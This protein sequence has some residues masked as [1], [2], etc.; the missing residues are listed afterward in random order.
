MAAAW[1]CFLTILLDG[2]DT[3]VISFAAPSLAHDWSLPAAAFTPAFVATSLGA[4]IGYVSCGHLAARFGHR[5]LVIASVSFFGLMSLATVLATDITELTVFRFVTALGLGGAIPTAIALASGHADASRREVTASI[6]TVAIVIGGTLGGLVA[7]PLLRRWGWQGPFVLGAILPFISL[8]ALIAWLPD[9]ASQGGRGSPKA[10]FAAGF[11]LPTILLWAM[12]FL[13]F[14]QSYSFTYWLPLLLTSF[15]FDRAS[16]ALG[17]T[18]IGAGGIAGV[19]LMACF[20]QRVGC[21]RYLAAA[22]TVGAGF[23]LLIAFGGLPNGTLPALLVL[24]GAGLG[25]G[26]VGQAAI[27]AMLYPAGLRTTGVGWSSAMGRAGSILGPG[28]AGAFLHLQW[29]A[30]SIVA[31]AAVPAIAAAA[32]A[33]AIFVLTPREG[34]PS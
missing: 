11:A 30:R 8:P 15:G 31:L 4:V 24:T 2:Y 7:V 10:L 26:G 29:P 21:A 25:I 32:S 22:F 1:L 17:N 6:V 9:G 28:I 13:S 18:Y 20:V 12:A 34:E 5:R 33:L 3:A 16:A 14:M 23:V 19:L 27:A